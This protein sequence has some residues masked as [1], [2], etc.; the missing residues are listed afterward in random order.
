MTCSFR[1]PHRSARRGAACLLTV[2][3][4]LSIGCS[5]PAEESTDPN[6][7]ATASWKVI[8]KGLAGAVL[9]IFID[10]GGEVWLAG[11]DRKG[12]GP[13]LMHRGAD[14]AW[15]TLEPG[16]TGDLWWVF[17]RKAGEIWTVGGNGRVIRHDVATGA[18]VPLATETTATLYGIW[19]AADGPLWAVG[20]FVF[21]SKKPGVLLRISGDKV[22]SVPLPPEVKPDESLFKVWGSAVDDVWVIGDKGSTLHFDG[23]A[24][25]YGQ[26]EGSPRLVTVHGG[27]KD[28]LVIVGGAMNGQIF[29]R[30]SDASWTPVTLDAMSALNG[31]YVRPDGSA[32]AAG[33]SGV[34][35]KRS[36]GKWADLPL[37]DLDAD[38]HATWME[39]DG[40]IWVAGGDLGSLTAMDEGA[41]LRYGTGPVN[42]QGATVPADAQGSS[43]DV[44]GP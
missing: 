13:T 10:A 16:G 20:G 32:S 19:G 11:A 15:Q 4:L 37:P 39:A 1:R 23:S 27:G 22:E 5:D 12:K 9:S 14:G 40:S 34:V 38:W 25:T 6:S 44:N 26:V 36:G 24:W 8:Q 18:F 2:V 42:G 3:L 33:M 21:D 7:P 30:K 28:D 29:E 35:L 41:V 17:S 31:V 43:Q